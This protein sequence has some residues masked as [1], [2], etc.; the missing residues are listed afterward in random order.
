C[1]VA[2]YHEIL[3][4]LTGQSVSI[5]RGVKFACSKVWSILMW[6]LFAGLVGLVVKTIEERLPLAGRI[7]GRIIGLAWS[8][9][10]V[11]S[12]PV[13]VREEQNANPIMVLRKSAGVLK[14]T[15][16][17]ALIGYVGLSFANGIIFL[18]SF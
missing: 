10:A 6:S 11:F 13:I 5:V 14:Q 4:A 2:F 15:W 17:E 7:I 12:I 18:A 16:G 9:A 3:A 8:I 1:N